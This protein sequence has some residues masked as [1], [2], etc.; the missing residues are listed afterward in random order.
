MYSITNKVTFR[1]LVCLI[2]LATQNHILAQSKSELDSVRQLLVELKDPAEK[3]EL[4][5]QLS[6]QQVYKQP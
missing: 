1:C 6:D 5:L 2:G 4:L 3:K